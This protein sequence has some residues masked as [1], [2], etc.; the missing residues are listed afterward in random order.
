MKVGKKVI[1]FWKP[2]RRKVFASIGLFVLSLT[3]Y[4]SLTRVLAAAH[5][6]VLFIFII[7][8]SPLMY[9]IFYQEFRPWEIS[10]LILALGFLWSYAL[11]CL[12]I[13]LHK[14]W[15]GV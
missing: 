2:D 9:F 1:Q 13:W 11:C 12:M 10:A 14:L 4:L 5:R 15:G 7:L 6:L 3:V 8:N